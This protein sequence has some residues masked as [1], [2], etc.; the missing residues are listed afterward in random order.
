M[1]LFIRMLFCMLVVFL[2]TSYIKYF[3]YRTQFQREN[4]KFGSQL[5]KKYNLFFEGSGGSINNGIYTVS[6]S[7]MTFSK[8]DIATARKLY[9]SIV[10]V[11]LEWL[12]GNKLY[13]PFLID[14]PMTFENVEL[15][16]S[17]YSEICQPINDD[18]DR[19]EFVFINRGLIFYDCNDE[20]KR[21]QT[22]H[23]ETYEE[24]L[25]IVKSQ[26]K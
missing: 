26:N 4:H 23:S 6:P 24:A 17:T 13:R 18:T 15:D 22:I 11:Y 8:L 20:N 19:V 12:N 25:K 2:T 3:P 1:R 5:A 10:E 16:L 21:Y 9:V 14:Y 7:Y